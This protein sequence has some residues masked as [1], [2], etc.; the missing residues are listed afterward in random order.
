M[1]PNRNGEEMEQRHREHTHAQ[2]MLAKVE[3]FLASTLPQAEFRQ[4]EGLAIGPFV[5][6]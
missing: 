2:E 4:Q 1:L 6:G 3:R 5:I